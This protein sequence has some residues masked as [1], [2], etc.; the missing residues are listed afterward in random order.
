MPKTEEVAG[1]SN[2]S[3]LA[4]L[5]KLL[6]V[7]MSKEEVEKEKLSISPDCFGKIIPDFDGDSVSVKI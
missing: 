5:I 7:K 2:E 6:T 3:E 4:M 1:G